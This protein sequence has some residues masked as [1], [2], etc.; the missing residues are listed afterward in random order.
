MISIVTQ[1]KG[2]GYP[3]FLNCDTVSLGIKVR[4]HYVIIFMLGLI[5]N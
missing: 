5:T 1:P 3:L 4:R 2:C